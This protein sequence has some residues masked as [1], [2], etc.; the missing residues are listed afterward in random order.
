MGLWAGLITFAN[1]N[2][3][4]WLRLPTLP[5][6]VLGTAA[7]YGGELTSSFLR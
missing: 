7:K 6:T 1:E 4:P 2:G 3:L 5:V